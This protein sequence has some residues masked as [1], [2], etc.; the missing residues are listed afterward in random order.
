MNTDM[1]TSKKPAIFIRY[2]TWPRSAWSAGM[3]RHAVNTRFTLRTGRVGLSLFVARSTASPMQL[4]AIAGL[5]TLNGLL[6]LALG[7]VL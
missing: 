5:L 3:G 4:A 2:E 7:G 1:N 6:A